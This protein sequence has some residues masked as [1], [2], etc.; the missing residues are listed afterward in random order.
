VIVR[1]YLIFMKKL[2]WI[3]IPSSRSARTARLS[4]VSIEPQS[5]VGIQI[6]FPLL[7]LPSTSVVRTMNFQSL[8]SDSVVVR[9][10]LLICALDFLQ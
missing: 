2:F 4:F 6:D 9:V 5:R 7:L 3:R 8:F 1:S 10:W